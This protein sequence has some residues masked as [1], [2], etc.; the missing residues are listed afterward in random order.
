MKTKFKLLKIAGYIFTLLLLV[1]CT[2][3][4]TGISYSSTEN[5]FENALYGSGLPEKYAETGPWEMGLTF[6]SH[7]NGMIKSINIKN[8]ELGN[9]RVSI[10]DTN[11][12]VLITSFEFRTES[13]KDFQK[14]FINFKVE[15][16][17][18]YTISMNATRYFY[19][20]L[21]YRKLPMSDDNLTLLSTNFTRGTWQQFP[22]QQI[23][24]IIH[25]LID[26]DFEWIVN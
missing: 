17:R 15:K 10:W 24:N 21:Y 18:T 16:G 20:E 23:D 3:I 7:K 13:D 1:Q 5:Y 9:K 6:V 19:H 25:G 22:E 12:R 8:P 14:K 26:I 11:N 2:A 4:G